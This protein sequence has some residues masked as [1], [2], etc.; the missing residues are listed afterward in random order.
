MKPIIPLN[1]EGIDPDIWEIKEIQ[2]DTQKPD[3]YV[4]RIVRKE[5][6]EYGKAVW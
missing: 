1:I 2:G 6:K 5:Q 4:I 3:E